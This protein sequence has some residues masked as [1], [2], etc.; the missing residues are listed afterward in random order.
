ML[1]IAPILIAALLLAGCA[2]GPEEAD[3]AVNKDVSHDAA[4]AQL[5]SSD[6][7]GGTGGTQATT[8]KP[9]TSPD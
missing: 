4:P 1:K 2:S 9:T 8:D 7:A 5:Q 3:G 6:S